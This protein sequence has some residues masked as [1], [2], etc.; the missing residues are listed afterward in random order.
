MTVDQCPLKSYVPIGGRGVQSVAFPCVSGASRPHCT[1]TCGGVRYILTYMMVPQNNNIAGARKL[2]FL[3]YFIVRMSSRACDVMFCGILHG[4][5]RPS[6]K[7]IYRV[8][9]T[10]QANWNIAPLRP[11]MSRATCYSDVSLVPASPWLPPFCCP[12]G[13]RS[14]DDRA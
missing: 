1:E 14:L 9:I 7:S 8:Y 6:C 5:V 4:F 12:C 13:T 3:Y 2:C 10:N 11:V